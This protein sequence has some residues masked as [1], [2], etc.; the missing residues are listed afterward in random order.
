[1]RGIDRVEMTVRHHLA[2]GIDMVEIAIHQ[3]EAPSYRCPVLKGASQ[4]CEMIRV[5]NVVLIQEGNVAAPAS[6]DRHIARRGLASVRL[7]YQGY[8]T[9]YCE[10]AHNIH[11]IVCR[12]I[13]HDDDFI[14]RTGLRKYAFE[15]FPDKRFAIEEWNYRCDCDGRH[16]RLPR[17]ARHVP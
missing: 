13:I 5:P 14:W 9:G 10:F 17:I 8:G 11:A 4:S 15:G 2:A 7:R 3:R 12:S 16:L 6:I 1:M